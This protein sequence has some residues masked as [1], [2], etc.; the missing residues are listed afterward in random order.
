[1]KLS[2]ITIKGTGQ[3]NGPVIID[4]TFEIESNIAN[5]FV[6]PKKQQVVEDFLKQ[7]YPGV[8]ID[9]NRLGINIVQ[10]ESK[11]KSNI[12]SAPKVETKNDKENTIVNSKKNNQTS[13]FNLKDE[14]N[15]IEL[16]YFKKQKET[17]FKI[18]QKLNR[19]KNRDEK[20]QIIKDSIDNGENKLFG[21]SKIL[22]AYLDTWWKKAIAIY[23]ILLLISEIAS[24]LGITK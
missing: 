16:E 14:Q 11:I 2:R 24:Y 20:I 23:V 22:W 12:T 19:Q 21:Y 8:K 6:G 1:M 15:K 17:E 4:K 9:A 18:Q 7:H 5:S 10:L 3:L 13:N